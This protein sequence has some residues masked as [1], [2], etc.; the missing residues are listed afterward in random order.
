VEFIQIGETRRLTV[1]LEPGT[2]QL[3]TRASERYV[4]L[5][6]RCSIESVEEW[7]HPGV[8]KT[9]KYR[10]DTIKALPSF[11]QRLKAFLLRREQPLPRA[12]T[13]VDRKAK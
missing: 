6:T 11:W 3:G 2:Y 5:R 4:V 1:V 8:W 9:Q 7:I 13:I 12:I 10:L